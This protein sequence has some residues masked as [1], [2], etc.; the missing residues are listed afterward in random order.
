[1]RCRFNYPMTNCYKKAVVEIMDINGKWIPMC[2][3]HWTGK[4]VQN[5]S[6][7]GR[8]ADKLKVRKL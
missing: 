4:E 8:F 1:M 5:N 3:D 2:D 7:Y 6:L